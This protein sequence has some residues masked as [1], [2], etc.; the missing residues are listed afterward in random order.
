MKTFR[1]VIVLFLTTLL[2]FG[3][4]YPL[5]V[6]AIGQ[7]A[8]YQSSGMPLMANGQLVGYENVGQPFSEPQY[9]WGRPSAVDYN[10]LGH[11]GL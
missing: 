4:A 5:L 10:A 11:G 8:P 1:N 2:L 9:F 7:I 6:Y 3:V